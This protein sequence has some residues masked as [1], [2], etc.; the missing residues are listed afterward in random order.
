VKL[1]AAATGRYFCLESLSAFDGQPFTA[2]AELNLL[3]V[4]GKA[5]SHEGWTIAY[6]RP[7]R[8]IVA[9]PGRVNVIG[10]HTDYNDGFVLPMAIERYAI[11]AADS[12]AAPDIIS[13]YDTHF[14]EN[15]TI[16]VSAP[17]TKGSPKWSN[18][19]RGALCGFQNRGVKVPT[20]DV[21]F[22][23]TVPLGGGLCA[24]RRL[25]DH[26]SKPS[27]FRR[28]RQGIAETVEKLRLKGS[29]FAMMAL[30]KTGPAKAGDCT[31]TNEMPAQIPYLMD[32]QGYAFNQKSF[33]L[34]KQNTN[35]LRNLQFIGRQWF[36]SFSLPAR[37]TSWSLWN[38]SNF[39]YVGRNTDQI[40]VLAPYAAFSRYECDI[41][42]SFDF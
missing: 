19:I 21:A 14:K 22:M 6:N 42:Y 7:P 27:L 4:D 38:N 24:D 15:A 25:A 35:S 2:V 18:Y 39:K 31:G 20:L 37:K 23:S 13:I 28:S 36:I 10:E 17:V 3:D 11:M 5:L 32:S 1:P 26:G 12:A 33:S 40:S 9:A 41:T 16:D 34:P 30:L 8:W 29:L